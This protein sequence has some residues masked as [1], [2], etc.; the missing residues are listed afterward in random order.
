MAAHAHHFRPV[1]LRQDLI[2][3]VA[4][5]LIT[6]FSA[7]RI[8][9]NFSPTGGRKVI[10]TFNILIFFASAVRALWF[11]IPNDLL[12][13]SYTP[14]PQ[15]AYTSEGWLG[16]LI[17]ELML[18]SG[19]ICLYGIFILVACYWV[20]MLQKLNSNVAPPP[21]SGFARFKASNLGTMETFAL[22]MS[23]I[24]F[25]EGI[26][27]SL[28]LSNVFNSEQMILY[29]SIMLSV[30]SVAVISEITILS[31]QIQEVLQNLEAINNRNSQPQIRRIFAIIVI[32][33]VFF[34]TR[35][36]LECT[37]AVALVQLMRG[38]SNACSLTS[39]GIM[40][41]ILPLYIS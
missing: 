27:I 33:N 13:V 17:S 20:N 21:R 7:V 10:T 2:L 32:A 28:F 14:R 41:D 9:R 16:T 6:G 29:D 19:S 40:T 35:V 18:V 37:L 31:N 15:M 39:P 8:I 11:L 34:I 22:I 12:E 38:M 23:F 5:L 4:F 3:G 25:C 26:N 30:F 1:E 24:I 36:I